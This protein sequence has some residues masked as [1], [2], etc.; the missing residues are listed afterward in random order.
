MSLVKRQR[1]ID[2]ADFTWRALA[3][4]LP[5][6]RRRKLVGKSGSGKWNAAAAGKPCSRHWEATKE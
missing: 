2:F 6:R 3:K 4:F 1:A 5:F